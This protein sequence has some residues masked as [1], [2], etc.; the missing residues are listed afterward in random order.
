M[1]WEFGQDHLG[2]VWIQSIDVLPRRVTSY[3]NHADVLIT[4]IL[5]SKPIEYTEQATG[6]NLSGRHNN[7]STRGPEEGVILEDA[8][9]PYVDITPL[10]DNM[11]PIQE[12]RRARN[13]YRKN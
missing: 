6:L 5:T 12:Y 10:L 7:Y 3:G 4:G 11:L 1:E 8:I 9:H 13:V 2:R